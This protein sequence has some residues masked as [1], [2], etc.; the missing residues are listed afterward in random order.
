[1]E[2]TDHDQLFETFRAETEEQLAE[3]EAG[4]VTLEAHPEDTDALDMT[5]RAAHTLKGNAASLGFEAM[6]ELAHAIEDLLDRLRSHDVVASDGVVTLLLRAVDVMRRLVP[7]TV[8]DQEPLQPRARQL[9]ADLASAGGATLAVAPAAED[10]GSSAGSAARTL[11]VDVRRLDRMLDLTGELAVVRGRFVEMLADASGAALAEAHR[12][13]ERIFMDLQEEVLRARMVPLGPA[14]RQQRR[15]LRDAAR[16]AGKL[17]RLELDGED[18]EVDTTIVEQMRGPL[19]HMVR[20]AVDHGIETPDVRAQLGKDPRGLIVL[21]ARHA[22]GG[23]VIEVSDDG[24]GLDRERI[25]ARGR[26]RGLTAHTDGS[27]DHELLRLIVEPGFSTAATVTE[28]SGRGIGMDVVRRN[29]E[30]LRGSVQL[31]SR[32]GL[33]TTFRVRLPLTVALIQGF[34]VAAGSETY[35]IPMDSVLECVD[36]GVDRNAQAAADVVNVRGEVVPCVQLRQAFGLP[37]APPVRES[38]VVVGDRGRR[39]GFA[40]DALLGERQIVIKPLGRLLKGLHGVVGSTILGNGRAALILDVPALA[41]AAERTLGR[42]ESAGGRLWL[43][44]SRERQRRAQC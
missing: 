18:V 34:V 27:A 14:F 4:L 26:A 35:V 37:G 13:S 43:E 21:R 39:I 22:A 24:A 7:R 23:V 6:A 41:A 19:T 9:L 8:D 3:M 1:M 12:E 15:T 31:E 5:F 20:N 10:V 16:V 11:R 25:A 33:G 29:V 32:P 42:S 30:A 38:L 17:V 28:L 2:A 44:Q 40:V 36:L